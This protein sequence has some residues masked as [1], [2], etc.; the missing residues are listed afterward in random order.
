MR[1]VSPREH[2]ASLSRNVRRTRYGGLWL[3]LLLNRPH[4]HPALELGVL[5]APGLCLHLVAP[6]HHLL[7]C[8]ILFSELT[9][10]A[11]LS[12]THS[13][14]FVRER[15][16]E[17]AMTSLL[18]PLYSFAHCASYLSALLELFVAARSGIHH[19]RRRI[20]NHVSLLRA[21]QTLSIVSL[22]QK[23]RLRYS[24]NPPCCG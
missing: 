23:I 3:G 17:M 13:S 18:V 8:F 2:A 4:Q 9:R 6:Q 22:G 19:G 11:K 5:V 12:S 24:L 16:P 10:I 14:I 20:G 21:W 1:G 7:L 15:L